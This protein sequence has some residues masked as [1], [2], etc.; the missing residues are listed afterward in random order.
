MG[1]S[2]REYFIVLHHHLFQRTDELGDGWLLSPLLDFFLDLHGDFVL[3]NGLDLA[4]A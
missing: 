4:S 2:F 3:D 1:E